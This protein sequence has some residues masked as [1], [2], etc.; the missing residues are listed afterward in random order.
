M[1]ELIDGIKQWAV[2]TIDTFGYVGIFTLMVAEAIVFVIPSEVIMPVAGLLA[3]EGKI[4]FFWAGIVGSL[5]SLV[6]AWMIYYIGAVG[7]RPLLIRYGRWVTIKEK[8]IERAEVWFARY[9]RAAVLISRLF[10]VVR[11]LISLPAG[12][13]RMPLGRFSL[14][15]FI[16]VLPWTFALEAAGFAL[17]RRWELILPYLDRATYVVAGLLVVW[18]AVWFWRR[19]VRAR[20]LAE[21]EPNP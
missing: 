17:G 18:A 19:R 14:Y 21:E 7:G 16:G 9:G 1:E 4:S 15:T 2:A 11:T 6:G 20:S 3:A 8:D 5:G 12:V 10:P 13:A